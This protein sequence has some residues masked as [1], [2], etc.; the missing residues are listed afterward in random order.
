MMKAVLKT[1][2]LSFGGGIALGAGI[3]L[4][5]GP[6]KSRRGET[7]VDGVNLDPLLAR[8]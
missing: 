7:G 2:A 8:L 6:A 3:R 1:L 5:Q 4:T